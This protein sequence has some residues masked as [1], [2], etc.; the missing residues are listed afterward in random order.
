[1]I[2]IAEGLTSRQAEAAKRKGERDLQP[3]TVKELVTGKEQSRT[4]AKSYFTKMRKKDC[5]QKL[6]EWLK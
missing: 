1:M 3:R 2:G 5:N 6:I 4:V